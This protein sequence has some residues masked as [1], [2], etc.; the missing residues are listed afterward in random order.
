MTACEGAI[1]SD[2][3]G[4]FG[5]ECLDMPI[6]L[7]EPLPA[8]ALEESHREVLLPIPERGPIT[9]Q[10]VAGIDKFSHLGLLRASSR[11]DRRLQGGGHAGQQPERSAGHVP[12]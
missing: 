3:A 5:I 4:D 10:A 6:D 7:F 12:G 2:P 1:G 9:H 11:S 8:L